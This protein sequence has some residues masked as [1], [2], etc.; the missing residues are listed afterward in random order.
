MQ[1]DWGGGSRTCAGISR[2]SF[3]KVGA[4][5][6]LGLS[7]G[8]LAAQRQAAAAEGGRP[9]SMIFIW[10]DGG[11]SHLE[12]FDLKPEAPEETRGEFKP[13][14]TNVPGIQI[15]EH[16]PK[17]ARV[18]DLYSIIRS[19]THTDSNHGA[20]NHLMTT[21]RSTPV[22]VGCGNSV[23]Y[24]PSLGSFAAHERTAPHGLPPYLTLGRAMRSGGPN[25]LGARYAP[26]V[27]GSDPNSP[28]FQ[29]EDVSLPAGIDT[30]RLDARRGLLR[31]VDRLQ[32]LADQPNDPITGHDSYA[33]RALE[34]MTSREAKAAFEINGEA[35]A[36]RDRYGRTRFGQQCLLARRLVEAGVPWISIHWGGWDHHF[37]LFNDMKRMLPE[38]DP[39]LAALL[40]DL[41]DRGLLD[42]TLVTMLGEFGRTPRVNKGPGR[43]HWGPGMSIAIAGG[44]TPGGVVVGATGPDGHSPVERPLS[45]QDFACTILSKIGVDYRKEFHNELGRPV[46]MV[47]GGE[48]ISELM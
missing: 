45:P 48:P 10:L 11:P 16:L 27:V 2:R 19:V 22:P 26:L 17:L 29:V 12:T 46:Q 36:V 47:T 37:N 31:Q 15:C 14:A 40:F 3:L 39:A 21:G 5:P 6:V 24:H 38:L 25:F 30:A 33:R 4:L 7:L 41:K 28:D 42:T 32:R 20:G 35:A 43:D 9:A 18:Q 8:E 13:I 1:I 23:S 34:L 44:G